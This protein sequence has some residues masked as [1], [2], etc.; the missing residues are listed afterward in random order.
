MKNLLCAVIALDIASLFRLSPARTSDSRLI[1]ML[2]GDEKYG[3]IANI[4][5]WE[6]LAVALLYAVWQINRR[7]SRFGS[8]TERILREFVLHLPNVDRAVG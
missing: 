7:V 5:L 1:F 8:A 3:E 2:I 6:A 4:V